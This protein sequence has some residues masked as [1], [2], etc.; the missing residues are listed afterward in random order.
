MTYLQF[1][2]FFYF[3]NGFENC[4]LKYESMVADKSSTLNSHYGCI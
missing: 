4:A 3:K 2:F 1:N